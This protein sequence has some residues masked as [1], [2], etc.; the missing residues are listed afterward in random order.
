VLVTDGELTPDELCLELADA[1]RDGGPWG[2]GFPE[3]LFDGVF[4]L[5]DCRTVGE[6]HLKLSVQPAGV[7]RRFDAIAFNTPT[8]AGVAGAR[9]RLVYRLDV[10][11]WRGNRRVQLIV[12]HMEPA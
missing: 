7:R 12:E 1:L 9:S 5:L 4:E 8:E 2:Q 11:E 10:N 6:R 3:P